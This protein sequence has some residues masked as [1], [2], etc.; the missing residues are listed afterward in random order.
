V[1]DSYWRTI[2][3]NRGFF[4]GTFENPISEAFIHEYK[5]QMQLHQRLLHRIQR[6]SV[7]SS[8]RGVQKEY[9]NIAL[10]VAHAQV[11]QF[12]LAMRQHAGH[13]CFA[14]TEG[15]QMALVPQLSKPGDLICIFKGAQTPMLL[16]KSILG[17]E[18]DVQSRL[19]PGIWQKWFDEMYPFPSLMA[20]A[21]TQYLSWQKSSSS[22]AN[23]MF[24][25]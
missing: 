13:R 9:E 15:R 17:G 6:Y 21:Q 5:S 25:G 20:P 10:E 4:N 24:T 8:P 1:L 16:R 22:W 12:G 14:V 19:D 23:V 3:G 18:N 11:T 7:T 2:C